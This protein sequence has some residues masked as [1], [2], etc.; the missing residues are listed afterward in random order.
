MKHDTIDEML[1][2]LFSKIITLVVVGCL[3]IIFY[4]ILR[5]EVK[6]YTILL[7]TNILGTIIGPA[8]LMATAMSSAQGTTVG[9]NVMFYTCIAGVLLVFICLLLSFIFISIT[10]DT[11]KAIRVLKIPVLYAIAWVCLGLIIATVL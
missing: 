2:I 8:A 6:N 10:K 3:G 4:K 11:S 7:L 9:L 5:S 1:A